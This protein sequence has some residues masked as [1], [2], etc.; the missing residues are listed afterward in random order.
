MRCQVICRSGN[1]CRNRARFFVKI[2]G[3]WSGYCR[4]HLPAIPI[5]DVEAYFEYEPKKDEYL[6]YAR[7]EQLAKEWRERT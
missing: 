2:D 7:L 4:R 6:N 3:V 5:G 1:A